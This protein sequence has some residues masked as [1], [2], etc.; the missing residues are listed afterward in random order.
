MPAESTSMHGFILDVLLLHLV[1]A[2]VN[3]LCKAFF[4][5]VNHLTMHTFPHAALLPL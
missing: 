1:I 5:V 3:V 4:V 2:D